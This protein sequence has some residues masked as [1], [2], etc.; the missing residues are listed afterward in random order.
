VQDVYDSIVKEVPNALVAHVH[1]GRTCESSDLIS[2]GSSLD[3]G[4][5]FRGNLPSFILVDSCEQSAALAIGLLRSRGGQSEGPVI[6]VLLE[7]DATVDFVQIVE[8]VPDL[9][10]SGADDVI[11]IPTGTTNFKFSI[12][13]SLAKAKASRNQRIQFANQ[14]RASRKQCN[15]LFWEI[16]D[17]I[18]ENFPKIQ[19]QLHEIP[20]KRVGPMNLVGKLGE[21]AFGCV[22]KWEDRVRNTS[23]AVKV[24]A[25]SQ[26]ASASH[27]MQIAT[28][29]TLLQRCTHENVV[30]FFGAG[31]GM[32]CVY[33]FMEM[34]GDRNLFQVIRAEGA[35]GL[36]WARAGAFFSQIAA[37]VAHCHKMRVAH[38]DLKPENI[39]I[40]ET[41]CAK[42]IDFGQAVDLAGDVAALQSPLGTMPFT[43]PEI[44][45]LCPD[46]MPAPA[47]VW[48]LAVI[49]VEM[50]G[51][52]HSF[53][54]LLGWQVLGKD[55]TN[56]SKLVLRADDLQAFFAKDE[57]NGHAKALMAI[58]GLCHELPPPPVMELLGNMLE[59]MPEDRILAESAAECLENL[60]D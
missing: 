38:C 34:G 20:E 37:G 35:P 43:A 39:V 12:L 60:S 19:P 25:K 41:G 1:D 14:I 8:K 9:V 55:L 47:D 7:Q 23:G 18:V 27:A 16:A 4:K 58:S 24:F 49:V 5:A 54:H 53:V 40:S 56:L 6:V 52:N 21:G 28:E 17:E 10:N 42:I 44:M 36:P 3:F 59:F 46:W 51:G 2:I 11:M 57:T 50:L 30:K 32:R 26:V 45:C 33:L 13:V 15:R 29:L 22:Y 31:H 48:S